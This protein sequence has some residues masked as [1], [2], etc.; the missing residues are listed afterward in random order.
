MNPR[1]SYKKIERAAS[2]LVCGWVI[3]N[4]IGTASIIFSIY[5]IWWKWHFGLLGILIFVL[6]T[7]LVNGVILPF[8]FGIFNKPFAILARQGEV[9]LAEQGVIDDL[10]IVK[11]TQVKVEQWPKYIVQNLSEENL[12]KIFHEYK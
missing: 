2:I 4:V 6:L 8:V 3:N 12:K 7:W 10:I 9:E 1:Q 5:L 11:L